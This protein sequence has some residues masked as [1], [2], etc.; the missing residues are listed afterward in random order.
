MTR[1]VLA[2]FSRKQ[3]TVRTQPKTGVF[4]KNGTVCFVR[5]RQDAVMYVGGGE[6]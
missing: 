5:L 1:I 4:L 3:Q 2:A 6:C